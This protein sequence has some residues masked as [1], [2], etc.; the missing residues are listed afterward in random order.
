MFIFVILSSFH[1]NINS[2]EMVQFTNKLEKL[3]RSA[4]PL[5]IR[6]TLNDLAFQMKKVTIPKITR[7]T[8]EER[9]PNFFKA[10]SKVEMAQGFSI[11]HMQSE[12]GMVSS[13]LHSPSTNYAVRDLAQQEQ[14]GIIHG[15]SFKPLPGARIS[16]TG[17]IRANSRI[18]QILKAGNLIDSHDS[19]S[20]NR[21]QRLIKAS[22]HAGV[23]GFVLGDKI[24]WRVTS[25]KRV[26]R[27]TVFKK[28]KLYSFKKSGVAKVH[29]T[30]F[31]K[32][33][34]EEVVKEVEFFY[35]LQ[36]QKQFN[37][38]LK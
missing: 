29:A 9:K 6:G 34:A 16:G 11:Q 4:L 13:G 31:M 38:V 8:F 35:K 15:R 22:V 1:V 23:G 14:G 28:E 19:K 17:N 27:N 26:G 24:L 2:S 10:N 36:A 32:R 33:A 18:S 20:S 7:Q 12:V 25:I 3:H 21:N 37:K 30:N 5:A